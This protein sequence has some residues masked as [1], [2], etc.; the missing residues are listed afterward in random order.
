VDVLGAERTKSLRLE[1]VSSAVEQGQ[2]VWLITLSMIP[3]ERGVSTGLAEALG[4]PAP[5]DY[6]VFTVVKDTG[7]VI[8]M[9]MRLLSAA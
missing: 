5:R 3:P 7:D 6:K 1:E 4:A 2:D 9:R 8:A